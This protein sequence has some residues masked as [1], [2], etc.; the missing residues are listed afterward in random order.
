MVRISFWVFSDDVNIL[1]GRVHTIKENAETLVVTSKE[2]GI[3]LNADKTKYMVM[4]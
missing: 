1:R 3:E 2:I 4:S